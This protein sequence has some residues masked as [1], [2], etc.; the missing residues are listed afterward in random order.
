MFGMDPA[1]LAQAK[2]IGDH[3]TATL[4]IDK[5]HGTFTMTLIAKDEEGKSAIGELTS[6]LSM[7]LANQLKMF[8]GI[9]GKIV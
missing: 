9:T 3:V 5:E 2:R 4:H 6:N 1:K 8:F 7:G